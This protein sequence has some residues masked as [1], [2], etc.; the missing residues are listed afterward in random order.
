MKILEL[1]DFFSN[2]GSNFIPSLSF[3][4]QKLKEQGHEVFFIFSKRN[5]SED[6]YKWEKPFAEKHKTELFDFSNRS[7]V[8]NVVEFIKKNKIDI[9]HGHFLASFYLSEI[10]RH[11]PKNVMF[12]EH[13]HS[14]PYSGKKTFKCRLKHFRNIFL[15][16]HDI[17]KICVANAMVQMTKYVYPF[18]ETLVLQNAVDFRRLNCTVD[19]NLIKKDV[20]LFGYSYYVKGVDVAIEALNMLNKKRKVT[21]DIVLSDHFEHNKNIIIEKYGKIPDF[22]NLLKPT[23]DVAHLYRNHKIYL[24]ASR[25][26]GLSYANIEAYYC[27]CN[28]VLSDILPNKEVGLSELEFFKSENA[29]DLMIKLDKA[30][31][32]PNCNSQKEVMEKFGLENWAS[33]LIAILFGG[34]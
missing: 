21:L 17:P 29:K 7:I 27:G 24:N 25:T 30:L 9:V 26:E 2:Y 20:L 18:C 1:C 33:K 4:E 15:L 32:K 6:F 28:C 23:N 8:K 19:D 3:L 10:K 31:D 14:V 13:I 22:I 12:F 16:R 11:S 5:L 34:N